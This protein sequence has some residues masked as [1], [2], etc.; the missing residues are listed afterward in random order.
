MK[1]TYKVC[2]IIVV[3]ILLSPLIVQARYF[4]KIE[5][6]KGKGKIAEPIFKVENLQNTIIKTIDKE[7]ILEEYNFVIKNY[8]IENNGINKRI[9]Q[10]DMKYNIQIVNEKSNFPY[11][12]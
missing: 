6:I 12:V 11:K 9:S 10:V 3:L 8:E 2:I 7:T 4:E 5:N 1:K